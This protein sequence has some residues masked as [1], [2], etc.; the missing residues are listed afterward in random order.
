VQIHAF[1][2][3][4]GKG[5]SAAVYTVVTQESGTTQGLITA[6]FRIAKQGLTIPRLELV[7]GHMAV[8]LAANVRESLNGFRL[9]PDIQC[10]LDSTVAL[11]WISDRGV[12][13]QFVAN[14]VR[15]IQ[16]HP[17]VIWR[18]VPTRENPADLGSR[19]GSVTDVDLWWKGPS[20]LADPEKWPP[21]IVTQSSPESRAE[22]KVQQELF[23]GAV[24]GSNDLDH[25]LGKFGLSK[26]RRVGAWVSRFTHNSRHPSYKIQGP[27]TTEEIDNQ[28]LLWIKR[29]Q[30]Q[31]MSDDKFLED[32]A[33]LHLE[34]N[35]EEVL[36]CKGRIQGEY[37]IYL[38]DSTLY[39]AKVVEYA[40]ES[41]L[42]GGISFTMAKVREK[43]WIP[44]LRKL[45]KRVLKKCWGC[46]RFYT[47][48]LRSPPA[49]LLPKDRTE[50]DTPFNVIGV[51]FAGPIKYLKTRKNEAKAY[52]VL[53]SCSLTRG[54]YLE[55]LKSLEVG[56]FIQSLKR[57]I[58]RRGRPS[59]VYSDNGKTFVAAA[60]WL[61][62][63]QR[64]ESF[65]DFL[66]E[67]S[68][69]W[70]FNLSR[71]PWWGGQFERLIGLMKSAFGTRIGTRIT[72]LGRAEQGS[73]WR[74]N[75]PE[76]PTTDVH[77]GRYSTTA[78][79]SKLVAVREHQYPT[80]YSTLPPGRERFKEASKVFT[81]M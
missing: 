22:R 1:G 54:V 36:V 48:S 60:K 56:E 67:H 53:Y 11:H 51:D 19:G 63:V 74:R 78:V 68:I 64:D 49:G 43:L 3:A 75:H 47:V 69:T 41:T 72:F 79:N 4:S 23:A 13:R 35:S 40:H 27:L 58:A 25:I 59:K 55:L 6:K 66:S 29:A 61:A 28:E 50:G 46:K 33:Q 18:H 21:N 8:N 80:R 2:D 77:G 15:K 71:A 5:I 65:N 24:E 17:N 7:A 42:H 9:D 32:K 57:F 20:W 38:S 12:Y 30:N 39:A 10:W 73:S 62:K 76:Q 34:S 16:S 44:R 31:G 37:P 52:V 45:A 14:R 81:E 26:A 70:Q